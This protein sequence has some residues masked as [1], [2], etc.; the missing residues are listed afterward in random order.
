[1]IITGSN[2][3]LGRALQDKYPKALALDVND[4]DITNEEAVSSYDWSN[5]DIILNGAAYTNVDGAETPEGQA[6]AWQVNAHGVSN[7]TRAAI[8]HDLTLVH[9]S[10]DY[11]F[12]GSKPIH[13]EAETLS[14]LSEYGQTKA[15]GDKAVMKVPK[16][17]LV[18]TSWL[19]GDGK[20]FVRTMLGLGQ[21]GISPTVVADQIGRPT[22][23]SELVRAIDHLLSTK[24]E[25]GTYNVSGGGEPVSW[26]DF[27]RAIFKEAGF[28]LSVTNT[29]TA[30][31]Y[32]DKLGFARRPLNSVFDLS[33]ME[34]TGFKFR[35]WRDDL[36]EYI[37]KELS[38]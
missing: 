28:N 27:T 13:T 38:A 37:R 17:Y 29:T 3:Q 26:A 10:T 19:I 34:R 6:A 4:L 30:E 9:V 16:Y 35:D 12:D 32:K 23:A 7:L 14:P 8:E 22:F 21:K 2:G 11:V 25:F 31:Y 18:R 24:A 1:M 20:N 36:K 33:K 5:V 15:A